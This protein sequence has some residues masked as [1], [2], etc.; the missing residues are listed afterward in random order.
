VSQRLLCDA[1]HFGQLLLGH[2]V[3]SARAGN[4]LSELAKKLF[5][6]HIC[7]SR[8]RIWTNTK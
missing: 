4:A 5:I 7:A 2:A 3:C 8:E 6:F 1:E